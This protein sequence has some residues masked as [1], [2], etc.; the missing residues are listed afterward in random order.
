MQVS[1]TEPGIIASKSTSEN[2]AVE[3]NVSFPLLFV[4]FFLFINIF[5][6]NDCEI[7]CIFCQDELL[8]PD[9]F[10]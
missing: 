1:C 2:T 9:I 8:R 7:H 4:Y 10:L 3:L 6:A 5:S